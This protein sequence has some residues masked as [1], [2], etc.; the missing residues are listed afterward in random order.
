MV[1]KGIKIVQRRNL[2][3][4]TSYWAVVIPYIKTDG[5][6]VKV[7]VCGTS[8]TSPLGDWN[9]TNVRNFGINHDY[10][11]VINGGIYIDPFS[12]EADGI[13]I[14]DGKIWKDTTSELF[15]QEQHVLGITAEGN[16]KTYFYESANNILEDGCIYAITGFVPLIKN[17]VRVKKEA[18]AVCPHGDKRHPRQIIGRFFNGDYFTFCCDGR[19]RT[20]NGMTLDECIDTI[21]QEFGTNVEFAFNLDGGGS[22]QSMIGKQLINSNVEGRPVP[23]VIVFE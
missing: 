8:P 19:K 23:N 9:S 18:F 20:E 22:T 11:H 13:T 7:K 21:L 10:L 5:C 2:K 16:F 6:Q 4:G 14:I 15:F 12:V 3:V 17:G 1:I